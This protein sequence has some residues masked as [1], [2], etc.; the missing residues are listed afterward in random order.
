VRFGNVLGSSG[1]VLAIFRDRIRRW[2][3]LPLTDPTATRY[4]M[5]GEEAVSLVMKADV[6]ARRP[7]TYWL[8]MGDPVPIGLLADNLMALEAAAGY[9]PVAIEI[10]GLGP[11]EKRFEELT[12]QGLRMCP[13]AQRRLW[14]ARQRPVAETEIART[15]ERLRTLVADGD[16][17]A[18]L[19]AFTAALVDFEPRAEARASAKRRSTAALREVA[20]KHA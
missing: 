20:R 15:V 6:L 11:G 8:D 4:V 16:F 7:E 3:P 13:T 18:A 10:V 5:T 9:P 12:T 19:E 14:V 2:L 1:S 17:E